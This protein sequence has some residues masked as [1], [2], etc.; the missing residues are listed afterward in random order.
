MKSYS[1]TKRAIKV[2]RNVADG[3]RGKGPINEGVGLLHLSQPF[4]IIRSELITDQS[5]ELEFY[6]GCKFPSGID[7]V[8]QP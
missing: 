4:Q 7:I 6:C 8:I 2:L 1:K 5:W 3:S